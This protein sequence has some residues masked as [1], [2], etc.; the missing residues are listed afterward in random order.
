MKAW[1]MRKEIHGIERAMKSLDEVY[2]RIEA[3]VQP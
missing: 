2:L 3:E 1:D